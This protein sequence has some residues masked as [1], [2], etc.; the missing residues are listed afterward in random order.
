MIYID[1]ANISWG[2]LVMCHMIADAPTELYIMAYR[3]GLRTSYLQNKD[4]P[5]EHYDVA[6]SIKR[7]AIEL[8]A[9]AVSTRELIEIIQKKRKNPG[10]CNIERRGI[11]KRKR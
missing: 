11:F 5:S 7:R 4:T 10:A 9:K 1:D 3:L 8:G 2:R 6:K